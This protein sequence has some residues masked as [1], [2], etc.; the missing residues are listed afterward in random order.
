[1]VVI[2]L[3]L[4]FPDQILFITVKQSLKQSVCV[5]SEAICIV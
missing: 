5:Y 4:L 3:N 1:V 2:K